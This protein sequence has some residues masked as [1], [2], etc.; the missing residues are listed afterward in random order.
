MLYNQI[1]LFT[2]SDRDEIKLYI[3]K[4]LNTQKSLPSDMYDTIC[5]DS[6]RTYQLVSPLLVH[7]VQQRV[8]QGHVL[9]PVGACEAQAEQRSRRTTADVKTDYDFFC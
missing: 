4:A 6:V 9:H 3:F 7:N 8:C 1:T 2:Y 5:K